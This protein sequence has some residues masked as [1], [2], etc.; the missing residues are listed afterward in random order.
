DI[1]WQRF[2]P[3]NHVYSQDKVAQ[4]EDHYTQHVQSQA[5][6]FHVLGVV[7]QGVVRRRQ[8][9]ARDGRQHEDGESNE[10]GASDPGVSAAKVLLDIPL[11]EQEENGR[12]EMGIDVDRL[13]VDIRPTAKR[14]VSR[15]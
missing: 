9:Q 1:A 8:R 10:I 5:E 2:T 11:A 12:D 6:M 3:E 14:S 7:H 4:Y 13:V 15:A